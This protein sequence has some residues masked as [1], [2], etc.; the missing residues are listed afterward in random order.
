M[1]VLSFQHQFE[2][3]M[4]TLSHCPKLATIASPTLD[5]DGNDGMEIEFKGSDS[6][7]TQAD[8]AINDH[9]KES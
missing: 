2:P 9:N 7:D 3:W 4:S 1:Q 5:S 8:I 6:E